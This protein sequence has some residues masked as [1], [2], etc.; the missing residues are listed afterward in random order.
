MESKC[1]AVDCLQSGSFSILA[2]D[3]TAKLYLIDK[4]LTSIKDEYT[5]KPY[6]NYVDK[7]RE[8][9]YEPWVEEVKF[10]PLGDKICYGTH[11]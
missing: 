10:S 9:I 6:K 1:R 2:A 11:G 5:G 7:K 3:S 8:K 4:D